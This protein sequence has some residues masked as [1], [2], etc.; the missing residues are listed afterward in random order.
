[1]T[2]SNQKFKT[3]RKDRLFYGRFVYCLGFQLDE[4]SC[5]R[6]LDHVM[7]DEFIERRKVWRDLAQQ[8]WKK[9]K[10]NSYGTILT[11]RWKDITEKTVEDL[12]A[13]AEVLLTSSEQFKLVVSASQGYVYTNSLQLLDQLDQLPELKHKTHTQAQ[14]SRPINT[15][16]LKNSKHHFRSY[17]KAVKLDPQQKQTLGDFLLNQQTHVRLSPSLLTWITQAFNR[18]QDY[19]FV[20]YDTPSWLTMLNLVHSGIIRKT[21]HIIPAK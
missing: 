2:N 10:K 18:T 21:M 7:I 14:I 11:H 9:S 4:I 19:F 15:I 20:D 16:Q 5:L 17:F 1:L 12:H 3:V 8:R 6:T 13:L